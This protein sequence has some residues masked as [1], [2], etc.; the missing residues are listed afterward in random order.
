MALKL[1]ASGKNTTLIES[2]GE[3]SPRGWGTWKQP[4]VPWCKLTGG[5]EAI[6]LT[7]PVRIE[8]ITG[9]VLTYQNGAN[10]GLISSGV[11]VRTGKIALYIQYVEPVQVI[12][13]R[14]A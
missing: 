1:V 2:S 7:G 12:I 13:T 10:L 11:Y 5:G 3:S 8:H 9:R 4:I 6:E 14:L